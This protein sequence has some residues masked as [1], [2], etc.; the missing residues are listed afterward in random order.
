MER[1]D[2]YRG[3]VRRYRKVRKLTGNV[4]REMLKV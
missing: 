3:V 1:C 2:G 4:I